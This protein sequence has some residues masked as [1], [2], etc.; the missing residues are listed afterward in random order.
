MGKEERILTCR[1]TKCLS[2][3]LCQ[4]LH[5]QVRTWQRISK[6]PALRL[7][8]TPC[9]NPA[10]IINKTNLV[11]SFSFKMT[12]STLLA[13]HRTHKFSKTLLAFLHSRRHSR[14]NTNIRRQTHRWR[15]LINGQ[16]PLCWTWHT[17]SGKGGHSTLR[18][19]HYRF[20]V[21]RV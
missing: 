19:S 11:I 20:G 6:C 13:T 9:S 21:R 15:S 4:S 7:R 17:L 3:I 12:C 5:W 2:N 1:R 16:L 18:T 10:Q 14:H 8:T